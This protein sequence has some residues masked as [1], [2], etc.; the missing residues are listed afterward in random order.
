MKTVVAD[1]P[2]QSLYIDHECSWWKITGDWHGQHDWSL[3][4]F[5]EKSISSWFKHSLHRE[6]VANTVT[7]MYQTY[8]ISIPYRSHTS[9]GFES[10][11]KY[12]NHNSQW[13][14]SQSSDRQRDEDVQEGRIISKV[15]A[16]SPALKFLCRGKIHRQDHIP[17][18]H[19]GRTTTPQGLAESRHDPETNWILTRWWRPYYH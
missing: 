16:T 12:F 2:L 1:Y 14:T 13:K 7:E 11:T 8:G 4:A 18:P 9:G 10:P 15:R 17:Y 5:V 3:Q 19:L 6:F